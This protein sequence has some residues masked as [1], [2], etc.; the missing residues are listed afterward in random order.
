VP[1]FVYRLKDLGF[2]VTA[3][4]ETGRDYH[5]DFDKPLLNWHYKISTNS[6]FV[7]IKI[8]PRHHRC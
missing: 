4:N 2:V 5:Y 6:V 8:S 7:S 3:H 1:L